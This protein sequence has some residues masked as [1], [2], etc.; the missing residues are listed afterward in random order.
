MKPC[1]ID[2][3]SKYGF[4]D[5]PHASGFLLLSWAVRGEPD[6]CLRCYRPD[7]CQTLS[8]TS[9]QPQQ[10]GYLS[11]QVKVGQLFQSDTWISYTPELKT[12][13]HGDTKESSLENLCNQIKELCDFLLNSGRLPTF[14]AVNSEE[15]LQPYPSRTAIL[16][17]VPR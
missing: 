17:T 1:I 9:V 15:A 8:M 5:K 4:A 12:I 11:V 16:V 13:A 6:V 7:F 3:K 14:H 10:D 2:H